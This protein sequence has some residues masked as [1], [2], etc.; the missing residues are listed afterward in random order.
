MNLYF[1]QKN[2]IKKFDLITVASK[3]LFNSKHR[4]KNYNIRLQNCNISL[5]NDFILILSSI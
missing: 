4:E 1:H 5:Q 3:Y 2:V